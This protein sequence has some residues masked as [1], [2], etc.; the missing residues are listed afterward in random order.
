MHMTTAVSVQL[1]LQVFAFV[2]FVV[3]TFPPANPYWN[4]LVSAGLACWVASQ[5]AASF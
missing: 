3:A 5:F 1:I 4:R 2:L